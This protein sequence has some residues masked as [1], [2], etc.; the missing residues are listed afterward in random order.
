MKMGCVGVGVGVVVLVSVETFVVGNSHALVECGCSSSAMLSSSRGP[1]SPFPQ[2][3]V[4]ARPFVNACTALRAVLSTWLAREPIGEVDA[5]RA[6]R[7]PAL[8]MRSKRCHI[9]CMVLGF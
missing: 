7:M 3:I 6:Q 1:I 2:R 4:G 8:I 9:E 5:G